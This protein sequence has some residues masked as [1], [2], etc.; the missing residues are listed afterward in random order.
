MEVRSKLTKPPRIRQSS[1]VLYNQEANDKGK[2]AWNDFPGST[3]RDP[4][5]TAAHEKAAIKVGTYSGMGLAGGAIGFAAGAIGG[6]AIECA[7]TCHL[8]SSW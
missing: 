8:P 2:G 1:G 5:V 7:A 6:T 4:A 3:G